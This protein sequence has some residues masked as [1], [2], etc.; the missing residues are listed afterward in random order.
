MRTNIRSECFAS[1]VATVTAAFNFS[2]YQVERS[3]INLISLAVS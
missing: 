2:P 3:I 1:K